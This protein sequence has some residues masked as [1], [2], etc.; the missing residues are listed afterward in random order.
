MFPCFSKDMGMNHTSQKQGPYA[1]WCPQFGTCWAAVQAAGVGQGKTLAS[2]QQPPV[3]TLEPSLSIWLYFESRV[4][5]ISTDDLHFP[6]FNCHFRVYP[7]FRH[8]HMASPRCGWCTI[9]ATFQ[10]SSGLPE[11]P[12]IMSLK[13]SP[14]NGIWWVSTQKLP[15]YWRSSWFWHH[16]NLEVPKF[17]DHIETGSPGSCLRSTCRGVNPSVAKVEVDPE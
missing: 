10:G 9:F 1:P 2:E 13:L 5:P 12:T 16:G 17:W 8:T 7:I 6:H 15:N 11:Q 14:K 3:S 4:P